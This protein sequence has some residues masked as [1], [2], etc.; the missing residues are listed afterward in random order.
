MQ[1]GEQQ[2][3]EAGASIGDIVSQAQRVSQLIAEIA[4]ATTE[5]SGGIAQVGDAIAQI[6][7]VTQQNAAL[8]EQSA[9]AADSLRGQAQRMAELVQVFRLRAA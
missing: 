5:Q 2:A 9:A 7:Q 3:D 1:L 6:D 8:V 4:H